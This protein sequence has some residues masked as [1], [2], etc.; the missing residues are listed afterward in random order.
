[1]EERGDG[2]LTE[3][4]VK[5][6]I[7]PPARCSGGDA[8]HSLL[9]DPGSSGA[10]TII[11]VEPQT[12]LKQNWFGSAVTAQHAD[13][14][15]MCTCF[16]SRSGLLTY[17]HGRRRTPTSRLA[18][19]DRN[20]AR[21]SGFNAAALLLV[22]SRNNGGRQRGGHPLSGGVSYRRFPAYIFYISCIRR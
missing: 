13:K 6:L 4:T 11:Q 1:M 9:E 10:A 2:E 18:V 21:K 19:R 14:G 5:M 8:T 17:E 20:K 7:T 15:Q 16:S 22:V 3:R 12:D